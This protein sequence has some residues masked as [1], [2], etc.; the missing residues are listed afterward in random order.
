MVPIIQI[1]EPRQLLQSI[2]SF[3]SAFNHQSPIPRISARKILLP[4]CTSTAPTRPLSEHDTNVLSDI[5][6]SIS[7]VA[8]LARDPRGKTKLQEW[9]GED[10]VREI[11]DF[12]LNEW[13]CE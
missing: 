10:I 7:D 2:D 13:Y 8:T 6:H 1:P 12:W 3:M 11:E 4:H 5:T 9:L